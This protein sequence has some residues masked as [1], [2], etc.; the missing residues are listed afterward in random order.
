MKTAEATATLT[1]TLNPCSDMKELMLQCR[2]CF[3]RWICCKRLSC[4]YLTIGGWRTLQHEEKT[5]QEHQLTIKKKKYTNLPPVCRLITIISVF[6]SL[7]LKRTLLIP[8]GKQTNTIRGGPKEEHFIDFHSVE[9][10]LKISDTWWWKRTVFFL[11]S[12]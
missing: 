7:K 2:R 6:E 5:P 10:N 4:S 1:L 3:L 9:H 11:F 8:E 12:F